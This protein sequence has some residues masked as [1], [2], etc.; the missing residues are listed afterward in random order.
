MP[1]IDVYAA[2]G[3]FPD[4]HALARTSQQQSCAGNRFPT[5]RCSR[6][7][8]PRSFTTWTKPRSRTSRREQLRPRPSAHPR[9]STRPRQAT[10]RRPGTHGNRRGRRRRPEPARAHVGAID[11]IAGRRL[12]DR[13]ARQH[14]LRHRRVG[15]RGTWQRRNVSESCFTPPAA[16]RRW[17]AWPD[18][19]RR[20]HR[21]GR[22]AAL[23]L[24]RCRLRPLPRR[25]LG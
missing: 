17:T 13:R 3:T 15:S 12:G 18:E 24:G 21:G 4:S 20:D 11:R 5:C 23:R 2:A 6:P 22:E 9:R 8:P 14:E 10:R 7:T 1:M 19:Q 25:G 16:T